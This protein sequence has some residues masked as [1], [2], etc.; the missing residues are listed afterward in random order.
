M[1][2]TSKQPPSEDELHAAEAGVGPVSRWAI[3][4]RMY[5][6]VLGFAH[7][8]HSSWSL[9]GLS[10]AESSFF[11][12]PPD[13]LLGPLCLGDRKKS[14]WFATVTTAASV[15]GAFLGYL[16][17]W[18][19]LDLALMIP[20][21]DQAKIDWLDQEFALRGQLWVF[22]AALTPI[23]FKLLTIT[24]GFA[25]MN[26]LVF[27][28]ACLVG[29]AARFYGVAFMFWWIGPKAIPFIDKYFNWLCIVFT[30]LLIAGFAAIKLIS[31]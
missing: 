18:G 15:L 1:D 2:S 27:A 10:F 8:R 29:R 9:F 12:I 6:W 23:P 13:V 16:I 5:D 19:F 31:G 22:V 26:L 24:A 17:G 14:W 21:I 4:R 11:P 25:K 3:H 20:G 28:A 7:S 30:V